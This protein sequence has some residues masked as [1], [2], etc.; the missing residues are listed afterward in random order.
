MSHDDVQWKILK[1]LEEI[2]GKLD[3]LISIVKLGEKNELT[4]LK[5][6][7]LGSSKVR[8]AIYELCNGEKTI[9]EIAV[10]VNQKLPNVSTELRY[11]EDS[12]LITIKK[13]GKNKYPQRVI[14]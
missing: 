11:L 7:V 6:Q 14:L 9:N 13:S 4:L 5:E 2:S 10:S 12:G 8:R 1:S 3:I